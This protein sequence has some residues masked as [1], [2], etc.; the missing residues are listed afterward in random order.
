MKKSIYLL[1]AMAM[2]ASCESATE[3][4]NVENG[5][6]SETPTLQELTFTTSINSLTKA[7]DSNFESGDVIAV[8]AYDTSGSLVE[9]AV[10]YTYNGSLFMSDTPI[11]YSDDDAV[12][13]FYSVYPTVS[14]LQSSLDFYALADQSADGAFEASD[15]L[16]ASITSSDS[17]PKLEFN[18]TMSSIVVNVVS[19]EE[20]SAIFNAKVGLR[21]GVT[22]GSTSALGN[23]VAITPASNG[24]ASY[25]LILAPQTV[26]SGSTL[27]TYTVGS[28]TYDWV[29]DADFEIVSGKQY[30]FNWSLA[31]REITLDSVINGWDVV[32]GGTI[33]SK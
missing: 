20:G 16:F 28:L 7:T 17:V 22:S 1:A 13:S 32:D 11:V 29:L 21:Y 4:P 14:S 15:M 5:G 10:Q 31:D 2:F 33:E 26:A 30:V 18:H 12:Y 25:K 8:T 3:D 19:D 23:S 6:N 24:T 9:D 27:A